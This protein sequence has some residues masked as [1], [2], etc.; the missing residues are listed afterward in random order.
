MALI[1]TVKKKGD[2]IL[3]ITKLDFCSILDK[4]KVCKRN[5]TKIK[6]YF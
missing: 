2:R 5:Y 6:G 4:K 1:A 3:I